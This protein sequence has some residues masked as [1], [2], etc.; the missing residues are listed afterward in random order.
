[1]DICAKKIS[2]KLTLIAMM[3]GT[4]AVTLKAQTPGTGQQQS[5]AKASVAAPTTG[6]TAR[7]PRMPD[8]KPDLSGIWSHSVLTPLQRPGG[9]YKEALTAEEASDLEEQVQQ[10]Q[11]DKRIENTVTPPGEQTTDAYNSFWR[12]GYFS[13]IPATSLRTSQVDDAPD[14]HIPELIPIAKNGEQK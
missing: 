10:R 4:M 8:G 5:A 11:I 1:M 14:G 12:A 3:V 6:R 9:L 2:S 7:I 13:K